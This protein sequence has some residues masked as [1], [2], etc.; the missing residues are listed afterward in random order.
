MRGLSLVAASEFRLLIAV[1][2]P[3][4]CVGSSGGRTQARSLPLLGSGAPA[5]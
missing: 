4:K 5:G 2:S 3:V 1:A